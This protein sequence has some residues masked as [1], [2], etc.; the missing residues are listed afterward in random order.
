MPQPTFETLIFAVEDGAW[1][2]SRY[3]FNKPH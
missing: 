2:I 1:K 3:L